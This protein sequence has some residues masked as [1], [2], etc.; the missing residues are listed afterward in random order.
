MVESF[1]Q[2]SIAMGTPPDNLVPWVASAQALSGEVTQASHTLE[3]MTAT[4]ADFVDA[5][6]HYARGLIARA[7]GELGQAE[8]A[9]HRA[10]AACRDAFVRT[11][12]VDCVELLAGLAVDLESYEEAARLLGASS[13]RRLRAGYAQPLLAQSA[14]DADVGTVVETIG[15]D[16]YDELTAEGAAMTWTEALDYATRGRGERKRPS[17]GWDSLTPAEQA[18]VKLVA[19]G[20]SN[21]QVAQRLFIARRTVGTHLTHIF[22]KLGLSNRAELTAAAVRRRP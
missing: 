2:V 9:A 7:C 5:A 4:T 8:D 15:A 3:G 22:A 16:R 11:F 21:Q 17:H 14:H 12:E 20:L 6:R 19:D 1:Q 10:L 13:A 18:V